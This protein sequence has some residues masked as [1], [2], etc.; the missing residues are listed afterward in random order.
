MTGMP[1]SAA[2]FV[3]RLYA[4][5]ANAGLLQGCHRLVEHSV[6]GTPSP[7]SSTN[8]SPDAWVAFIEPDETLLDGLAVAT[9]PSI[10]FPAGS[11]TGLKKGELLEV[12]GIRYRVRD[13]RPI[14][15][16]SEKRAHLS[17]ASEINT[18]AASG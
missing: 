12:D 1:A 2:S 8:A 11:L 17:R 6:D 4:A 5:A 3:E 7:D 10:R 16:G 13:V 18:V 9:N 14:G 15:D